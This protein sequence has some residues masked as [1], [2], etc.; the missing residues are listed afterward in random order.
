MHPV[1]QPG[2]RPG[3]R[4]ALVGEADARV[5]KAVLGHGVPA[6]SVALIDPLA[7]VLRGEGA[8]GNNQIKGAW[9]RREGVRLPGITKRRLPLHRP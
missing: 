6:I 2:I 9:A 5:A 1:P 3:V 8:K 7:S 4:A